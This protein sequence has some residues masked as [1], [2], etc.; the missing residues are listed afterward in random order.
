MSIQY[1]KYSRN[2]QRLL[3]LLKSSFQMLRKPIYP[4]LYNRSILLKFWR[5]ERGLLSYN[6]PSN[7]VLWK[8]FYQARID[9]FTFNQLQKKY[10]LDTPDQKHPVIMPT[11]IISGFLLGQKFRMTTDKSNT[12]RPSKAECIRC[13]PVN[14]SLV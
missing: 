14:G 11:D 3:M 5:R 10:L 13:F 6:T 7:M 2:I 12:H 9:I 4:D 8:A 1:W